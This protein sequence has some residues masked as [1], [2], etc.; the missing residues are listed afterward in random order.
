[1]IVG[2]DTR[3]LKLAISGQKTALEEICRELSLIADSGYQFHFLQPSFGPYTGKNKFKLAWE[4]IRYQWWKQIAL[5]LK[6]WR[7]K[8]DIV[9]CTDYFAPY[10]HL[11][12]KTVQVF[13]DAFFYEYPEHY[14]RIWLKLFTH[15]AL[16]A[17]RR[18]SFI[19]VPTDYAK[20]QIHRHYGI[21][22]NKLVTMYEGPKTIAS[23]STTNPPPQLQELLHHTYILHV[24]VLDKRKNL[25]ALITAFKELQ[26]IG[27]TNLKLVLAGKGS[28]KIYSDEE[29]YIR[30]MIRQLG[31]SD[32]VVLTGYLPDELLSFV[33]QHASLYVFPSFNEGFGIPVLEAFRFNLPI[34]VADNTALPEVGGDAVLTFN[35]FNP[36]D[37]CNKIKAVL[38]NDSL[39]TSLIRKG[40]QRLR[41]F[42][43][44]KTTRIILDVFKQTLS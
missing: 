32:A 35:P 18:S 43:W 27:Y 37:I 23:Y 29:A 34:L 20:K 3:D 7:K 5:P 8:C 24:G 10:I 6:A 31:L 1:M 16:P 22:W 19:L 17:A 28:G 40:Q 33:Y 25:P 30:K 38:D 12:F 14:N 15:I 39:R 4:H 42:S 9:F 13:H 44:A 26:S 2:I 21:E 11:G 36:S 41:Q